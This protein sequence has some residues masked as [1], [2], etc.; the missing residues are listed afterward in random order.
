[1]ITPRKTQDGIEPTCTNRNFKTPSMILIKSTLKNVHCLFVRFYLFLRLQFILR[2]LI[3]WKISVHLYCVCQIL[4]NVINTIVSDMEGNIRIDR[5]PFGHG[6]DRETDNSLA[7]G[8]GNIISNAP[9]HDSW[10]VCISWYCPPC[11]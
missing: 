4:V 5:L 11:Q 6:M 3:P 10:A 2:F 1:L 8:S 9:Y 7:Y